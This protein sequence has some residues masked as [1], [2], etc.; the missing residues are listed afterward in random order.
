VNGGGACARGGPAPVSTTVSAYSSVS[1]T[2]GASGSGVVSVTVCGSVSGSDVVANC[3]GGDGGTGGCTHVVATRTSTLG[4]PVV[5]AP[6]HVVVQGFPAPWGRRRPERRAVGHPKF[7]GSLPLVRPAILLVPFRTPLGPAVLRRIRG[8][9]SAS[10]CDLACGP[11]F[12]DHSFLLR[13]R[14][15]LY[16]LRTLLLFLFL[17]FSLSFP[18]KKLLLVLIED[19]SIAG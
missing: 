4:A 6:G 2:G 18:P 9:L 14:V 7:R 16:Q 19:L 1:G 13:F 10:V 11:N 3:C 15:L 17:T 8:S 5:R 12:R